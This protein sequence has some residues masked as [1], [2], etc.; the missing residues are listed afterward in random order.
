MGTQLIKKQKDFQGLCELV[1]PDKVSLAGN[2]L[3][4]A[5]CFQMSV[6]SFYC[7]PCYIQLVA[8]F[9]DRRHRIVN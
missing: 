8:E 1:A 6:S 3:Y 9:V 7:I 2:G 4:D 5:Q